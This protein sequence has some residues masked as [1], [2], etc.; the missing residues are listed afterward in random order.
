MSEIVVGMPQMAY[1]GMSENWLF[2]HAGARHWDALC[3]SMGVE[4]NALVDADGR[5]VYSSFVAIQAGFSEPLVGVRENDR[6]R[7]TVDLSRFG[8]SIFSSV[9]S[10]AGA[11]ADLTL[12]MTTK[13]VARAKEGS[14][15]LV[16]TTIRAASPSTAPE[17]DGPPVVTGRHR[18]LRG[19]ALPARWEFDGRFLPL[20]AE[21][22][23]LELNADPVATAIYEPTPYLD[24]NG[25]GLLYFASYPTI[26][27]TLERRMVRDGGFSPVAGEWAQCSGTV[28][29]EVYYYGNLDLGETVQAGMHAF[30]TVEGRDGAVALIHVRLCCKEDGRRIA[31]IF[32]AK[33]VRG[34]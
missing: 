6:F 7:E 24:Y 17:L 25:A 22:R 5:R 2:R 32:T 23:V 19:D 21:D 11:S 1:R 34:E 20:K 18:A 16:Q 26:A 8:Q 14:N 28:A 30:R 27:D 15:Q 9:Y 10:L 33:S 29:R 12:E 31:D 4:S 13:F 3:D